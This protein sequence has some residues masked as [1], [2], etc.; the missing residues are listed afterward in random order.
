M[1]IFYLVR[2][3]EPDWKFKDERNLKGAMR[4]YVPLTV[5]GVEQAEQAVNNNLYLKDCELI[6]SSPYTRSLQTAAIMNRYL[7]K[8]LQVEFDLHEWTPDNWQSATVKE[9]G[10]LWSDYMKHNGCHPPGE[11]RLW[12]TRESL[13]NRTSN[14]LKKYVNH[15][16]VMVVCHGMVIATLMELSSEDVNLC[17]VYEYVINQ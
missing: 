16:K 15:S 13:L 1:T 11:T 12:E 8:P 7:G 14:V 10:E 3:G 5:N 9:I 2:H 4:D 17:G 6:L